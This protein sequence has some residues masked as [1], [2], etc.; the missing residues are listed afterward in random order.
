MRKHPYYNKPVVV[1]AKPLQ[2][3]VPQPTI[4]TCPAHMYHPT[5]LDLK[6]PQWLPTYDT[7]DKLGLVSKVDNYHKS[8]DGYAIDRDGLIF[9]PIK[10]DE[11]HGGIITALACGRDDDGETNSTYT[12]IVNT[13]DAGLR[14]AHC[15][16]DG[17]VLDMGPVQ[18]MCFVGNRNRAEGMYVP[19][20]NTRAVAD[21]LCALE[22]FLDAATENDADLEPFEPIE[23]A[24]HLSPVVKD[25]SNGIPVIVE[26]PP[27]SAPVKK[28]HKC[29]CGGKCGK[30]K[31][32]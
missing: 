11:A 6:H 14:Y 18:N 21:A 24:D 30:H 22:N 27:M 12:N 3:N 31:H 28:E 19:L 9:D 29:T 16:E 10:L 32:K 13:E 7:V 1:E 8:T 20:S 5:V 26:M 15:R 23:N 17:T 4:G 25:L 2:P